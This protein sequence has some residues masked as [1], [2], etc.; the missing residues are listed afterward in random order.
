MAWGSKSRKRR[1][2][3][4]RQL[5]RVVQAAGLPSVAEL[6]D[7]VG[8]AMLVAVNRGTDERTAKTFAAWRL[9]EKLGLTLDQAVAI[10]KQADQH[11][12]KA[13]GAV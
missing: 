7:V 10:V 8:A 12:M 3:D 9:Q 4:A 11:V 5:R 2:K 13:L 1:A 6:V